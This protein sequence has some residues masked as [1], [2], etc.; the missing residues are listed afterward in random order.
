MFCPFLKI[1]DVRIKETISVRRVTFLFFFDRNNSVKYRVIHG[2]TKK[3]V[4]Y[5][6]KVQTGIF[7]ENGH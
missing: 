7:I 4:K 6:R 5:E 3:D 1:F 2:E